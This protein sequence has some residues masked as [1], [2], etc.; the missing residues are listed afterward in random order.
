MP[1]IER[2]SVMRNE[3]DVVEVRLLV[4]W[5]W[6]RLPRAPAMLAVLAHSEGDDI[7]GPGLAAL[8]HQRKHARAGLQALR[9]WH[10]V[11][12]PLEGASPCTQSS[13]R[14][15]SSAPTCRGPATSTTTCTCSSATP[16][17]STSSRPT[18]SRR[19][20]TPRPPRTWPAI[21]RL[22]RLLAR[23]DAEE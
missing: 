21:L 4:E 14:Q 12:E 15:S 10:L 17:A 16:S 20:T 6:P 1:G 22:E 19:W 8:A 5:A 9:R 2:L 3:D 18:S 23:L 7:D 13:V 11:Q